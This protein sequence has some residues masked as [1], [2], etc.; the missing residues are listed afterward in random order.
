MAEKERD[1]ILSCKSLKVGTVAMPKVQAGNQSVTGTGSVTVTG[2][3]TISAVLVTLGTDAALTGL[4]VTY[5][6]TGLTVTL[7]VW[8][9]TASGDC[10]PIAAT[11]AKTVSYAI[12]GS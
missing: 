10:T 11:A 12:F 2:M 9:P 5:A 3:T 1:G 6:I 8:K 7:K 4:F